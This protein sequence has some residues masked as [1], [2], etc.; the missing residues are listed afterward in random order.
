VL[1]SYIFPLKDTE[2]EITDYTNGIISLTNIEL[3][4]N[5]NSY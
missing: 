4:P 5:G 1:H 3:I 2:S